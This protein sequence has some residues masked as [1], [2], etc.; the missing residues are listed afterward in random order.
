MAY[1]L[2]RRARR[3]VLALWR[4]LAEDHQSAADRFVELSNPIASLM[5]PIRIAPLA[6]G[7]M[8][9]AIG[10]ARFAM[11]SIRDPLTIEQRG[12]NPFAYRFNSESDAALSEVAPVPQSNFKYDCPLYAP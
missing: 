1:R 7:A 6:I 8:S 12:R 11:V 10:L 5:A 4:H 9:E 2:T 3:D